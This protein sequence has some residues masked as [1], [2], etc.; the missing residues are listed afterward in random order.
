MKLLNNKMF[1]LKITTLTASRLFGALAT[2]ASS[3]IIA[4]YIGID[5]LG[6]YS[7][8]LAMASLLSVFAAGGF[9][10]IATVYTATYVSKN[11]LAK[12]KG[13]IK[14]G[15]TQTKLLSCLIVITFFLYNFLYDDRSLPYSVGISIILGIIIWA[16]FVCSFYGLILVGLEKQ[17]QGLLPE[18][19]FRPILLFAFISCVSILGISIDVFYLL[20]MLCVVM[21]F[22]TLILNYIFL[23]HTP[24]LKMVTENTTDKSTWRNAAYPWIITTIVWDFFIELHILMAGFFASSV[25]VAILHVAFRFR[26]LAGFGMRSLY[27]LFIPKIIAA[28][29]K[30][31]EKEIYALLQKLNKISVQYTIGVL[32]FFS[33]FGSFLLSI[34]GE[35][36]KTGWVLLMIV[37]STILIRAVM[38]P[39]NIILSMNGFQKTSAIVMFVC[40][41]I[42]VSIV[43]VLYP[44][45]G[46]LGIGI[47]YAVSNLIASITLWWCAKKFTKIDSSILSIRSRNKRPM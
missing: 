38:G 40:L 29:A 16:T 33:I 11:Q 2:F 19:L 30:S 24:K 23:K 1:I 12:L 31:D 10:S 8:F 34:F 18:T 22:T 20:V 26:V 25:D 35:E 15:K 47:A 37:S 5:I 44:W 43:Y 39:S 27:M 17:I 32:I 42:S 46:L 36:F 45:V 4:R 41:C 21:I 6:Q 14:S 3:L 9:P 7:F 28:N 13:F